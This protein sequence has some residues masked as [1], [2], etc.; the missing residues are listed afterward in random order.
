MIEGK[1]SD[2]F[3]SHSEKNNGRAL[4]RLSEWKK[5]KGVCP[6]D[7]NIIAPNRNKDKKQKKLLFNKEKIIK[8]YIRCRAK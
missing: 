4:C 1:C 7:K 6:Y 8:N 3:I 5:K 2:Y